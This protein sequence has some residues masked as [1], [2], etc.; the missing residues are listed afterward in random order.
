MKR[1]LLYLLVFSFC[2]QGVS[3]Q[4]LQVLT[5]EAVKV[6]LE[7]IS[8]Q[9]QSTPITKIQESDNSK[10]ET[11]S[12]TKLSESEDRNSNEESTTTTVARTTTTTVARTTTT[13]VARTTTTTSTT[14]TTLPWASYAGSRYE[15]VELLNGRGE[16]TSGSSSFTNTI[17]CDSIKENS[18]CSEYW[19]PSV[20][21]QYEIYDTMYSTL[22][23]EDAGYESYSMSDRDCGRYEKGQ[24]PTYVGKYD[25][26]TV[27][28][29]SVTCNDNYYPSEEKD[30]QLAQINGW[31]TYVC[32][33]GGSVRCYQYNGG[34]LHQAARGSVAYYCPYG[35]TGTCNEDGW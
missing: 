20:L 35:V 30:Y 6:A 7:E 31:E 34:S 2:S 9:A 33:R 27:S 25:K 19:F 11:P 10:I 8:Q 15:C 22:I 4:D 29:G 17:Y 12:S 5:E 14:T 1:I 24:D 23:C 3:E 26:C 21:L 16:C 13:T 32:E 18:N 28:Y